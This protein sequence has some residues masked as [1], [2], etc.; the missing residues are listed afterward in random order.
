[1]T[2]GSVVVVVVGAGGTVL[3]GAKYTVVQGPGFVM[4]CANV[5]HGLSPVV[6]VVALVVVASVVVVV[7]MV[8]VAS[9]L[10]VTLAV[11]VVTGFGGSGLV[12]I[13]EVVLDGVVT[14]VVIVA[15]AEWLKSKGLFNF[16]TPPVKRLAAATRR[17][18]FCSPTIS[19]LS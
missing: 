11:V 19:L 3:Q 4:F 8:V 12:N 16:I 10:V 5:V 14:G 15:P 2:G 1:V 18:L 17:L 7:A 9:V 13:I 6:V